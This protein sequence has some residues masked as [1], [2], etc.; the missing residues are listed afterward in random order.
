[1]ATQRYVRRARPLLAAAVGLLMVTAGS[2]SSCIPIEPEPVGCTTNADC[3]DADAFCAKPAGDCDGV[4]VCEG[5]PVICPLIWAPVCGCDGQTYGNACE[6]RGAGVN[7]DFAGECPPPVTDCWTN[8]DCRAAPTTDPSVALSGAFCAKPAGACDGPG[9]C[10]ARPELCLD[11]WLPVCGCDGRTYGNDC[12][13]HRNGVNVAHAGECE[14]PG[15]G[16]RTD[17]D[18]AASGTAIQ[19]TALPTALFC[20]KASGDCDGVGACTAPPTFCPMVWAPVCGCDGVTYG[21]TCSAHAARVNV[22][23]PGECDRP[24]DG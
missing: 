20:Q 14:A 22:A 3:L 21:N 17:A 23:C 7:V 10:T 18:C 16:C 6:A 15:E 19:P 11:V 8:D 24:V 12:Y 13:A 2:R 5:R 4:G 1:M 9:V